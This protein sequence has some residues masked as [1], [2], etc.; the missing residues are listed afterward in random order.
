MNLLGNITTVVST[1]AAAVATIFTARIAY[2]NEKQRKQE[3]VPVLCLYGGKAVCRVVAGECDDFGRL[4]EYERHLNSCSYPAL[5]FFKNL[6]KGPAS[7]ME[8][9]LNT[10]DIECHIGVPIT[11]PP[12]AVGEVKV[13]LPKQDVFYEI[14]VNLYYWDVE[15]KAYH[16]TSK[17][18]L[19]HQRTVEPDTGEEGALLDWRMKSETFAPIK[20]ERP[21]EVKHWQ[22]AEE[23]DIDCNKAELL[24]SQ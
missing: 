6:G 18:L 7:L 24:R 19:K 3:M 8:V 15:N 17:I 16:T 14:E 22:K 1:I 21:Q 11:I 4:I 2:I 10:R 5:L 9:E 20:K 12:D 13:W 23:Y